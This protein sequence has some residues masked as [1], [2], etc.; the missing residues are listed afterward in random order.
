MDPL[1]I[2]LYLVLGAFL[3][4]NIRRFL[5]RRSV[6]QVEPGGVP[7]GAV[8]LDVRTDRER[9]G[10]SIKGS[11]HIPLHEL[12]GRVDELRKHQGTQIVCY[13]QSGNRSL[14]A[15]VLLKKLGFSP[16]NLVGGIANWNISHKTR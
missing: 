1:Q 8:F 7:P 16:A 12:R 6:L 13:C 5:Q 4:L 9:S 10:G 15:A 14:V 2:V 11:L 3:I